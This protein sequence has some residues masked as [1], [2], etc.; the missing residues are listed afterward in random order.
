MKIFSLILCGGILAGEVLNVHTVCASCEQLAAGVKAQM[1]KTKK[2]N[3]GGGNTQW[4]EKTLGK[5]ATSET[6]LLEVMEHACGG[7]GINAGCHK[8]VETFEEE[9]KE[10]FFDEPE[11]SGVDF[12]QHFCVK[13]RKYCCSRKDQFGPKCQSCPKYHGM[14]CSGNG[15]CEGAGDKAGSGKCKCMQGYKGNNCRECSKNYFSNG[16]SQC[17]P[18]SQA[19]MEGKG[20]KGPDAWDCNACAKG[21]E[22]KKSREFRKVRMQEEKRQTRA[23]VIIYRFSLN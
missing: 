19:C 10:W 13:K 2:A 7:G 1:E 22:P 16:R 14:I 4:E 8:I 18:C 6:R 21:Y 3:F 20:C 15:K 17:K 23:V 5:W 9:I 12:R 11:K